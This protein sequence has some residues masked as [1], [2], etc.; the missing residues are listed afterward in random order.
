LLRKGL[1]KSIQAGRQTK[2]HLIVEK[3]TKEQSC[4]SK[5]HGMKQMNIYSSDN[6]RR[7]FVYFP[8]TAYLFWKSIEFFIDSIP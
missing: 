3:Q 8:V 7:K 5:H 4:R 1:E 6:R 2:E